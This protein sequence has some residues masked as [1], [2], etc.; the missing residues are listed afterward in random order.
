M[1]ATSA[2]RCRGRGGRVLVLAEDREAE[3]RRRTRTAS[4]HLAAEPPDRLV[5]EV[6]DERVQ[7]GDGRGEHVDRKRERRA[8]RQRL[9]ERRP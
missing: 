4:R 2:E 8:G 7:T 1:G 5:Q 3:R 9:G 6:D